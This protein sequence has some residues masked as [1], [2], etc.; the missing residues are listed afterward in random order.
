MALTICGDVV[1]VGSTPIKD[2][3]AGDKTPLQIPADP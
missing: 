2:P 1:I 3:A